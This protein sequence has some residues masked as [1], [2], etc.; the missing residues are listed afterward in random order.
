MATSTIKDS[1]IK[2]IKSD[3]NGIVEL[4]GHKNTQCVFFTQKALITLLISSGYQYINLNFIG[5]AAGITAIVNQSTG[6]IT[7]S[8]LRSNTKILYAFYTI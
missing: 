5:D 1:F 3:S 7:I 6:V 2:T 4:Q 8:G